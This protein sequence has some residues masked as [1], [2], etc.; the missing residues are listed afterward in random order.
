MGKIAHYMRQAE[1]LPERLMEGVPFTIIGLGGLGSPAGL[2]IG[3][4]GAQKMQLWDADRV[5]RHN[6][7][8]QFYG[9]DQLEQKKAEALASNI[10]EFAQ[11]RIESITRMYTDE[12]LG[13]IV[14]SGV[15]KIDIR[16]V[17][18]EGIKRN[19]KSISLYIECR[20]A[21]ELFQIFPVVMASDT[22]RDWY[23]TRLFSGK[24]PLQA[25]CTQGAVFYTVAA[26][27]GFVGDIVKKFLVGE[28]LPRGLTVDMKSFKIIPQWD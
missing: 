27:A 6:L 16:K 26:C 2:V 1:I 17:I 3:K 23:N 8:N 20:M 25:P 12:P 22:S 28:P 5:E 9:L 4:M 24:K 10:R 11:V 18:W 14:I 15:D 7:P 21:A 13:G 19:R